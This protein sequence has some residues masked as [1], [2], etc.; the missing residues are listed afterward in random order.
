[1]QNIGTWNSDLALFYLIVFLTPLWLKMI[2]WT[3]QAFNANTVTK[4]VEKPV[5]KTVSVPVYKDKIV[6]RERPIK[7]DK[8][9]Y[10]DR[11]VKKTQKNKPKKT[12]I[13]LAPVAS[14]KVATIVNSKMI[15]DVVSGLRILGVAKKDAKELV[16]KV[17]S[18][19][20]YSSAEELLGDSITELHKMRT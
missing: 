9:V 14:V 18:S 4:I 12:A 3:I 16:L 13:P 15:D 10:I 17:N 7:K 5:Y 1:M 6:Y 20:Q 8:I 2:F 19:K 11:P